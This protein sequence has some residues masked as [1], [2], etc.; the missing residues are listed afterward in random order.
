MSGIHQINYRLA[1]VLIVTLALIPMM[2]SADVYIHPPAVITTPGTYVLQS[3]LTNYAG[4]G[5]AVLILSNDVVLDGNGQILDGINAPSSQGIVVGFG[6]QRVHVKD[7]TVTDFSQGILYFIVSDGL[8]EHCT[9]T[10]NGIGIA[11]F[12]SNNIDVV[13]NTANANTNAGIAS[14]YGTDNVIENNGASGNPVGIY[15]F[16]SV[17][18][19]IIDNQATGNTLYGIWYVGNDGKLDQNDASTNRHIGIVAINSDDALIA[20][21]TVESNVYAIPFTLD[22]GIFVW[23]SPP[24]PHFI[25]STGLNIDNNSV[26]SNQNGIRLYF[27]SHD[28]NV[29]NNSVVLNNNNGIELRHFLTRYNRVDNNSVDDNYGYGIVLYGAPLNII[30]NNT[31]DNNVEGIVL[32][33][34]AGVNS[35]NNLVLNNTVI[36]S[37]L[38]GPPGSGMKGIRLEGISAASRITGNTI[39]SN[40]VKNYIEGIYLRFAGA[41]TILN[42]TIIGNTID[43]MWLSSSLLNT[44]YNNCFNNSVNV[45]FDPLTILPNNWNTL[46]APGPN[47]VG[48]KYFGGNYWA[49]PDGTGHSQ[50]T[51]PNADEFSNAALSIAAGNTDNFPLWNPL[52]ASFTVSD[53]SGNVPLTV[54]FT[55]TSLGNPTCWYWDLN[56][57]GIIDSRDQNPSYTYTEVGTYIITLTVS[58]CQAEGCAASSTY[59][60][61]IV[62]GPHADFSAQPTAGPAPLLVT[63]TDLSTPNNTTSWTWEYRLNGS[64]SW[65]Q[66]ST[67]KDPMYQFETPGIYDINLTVTGIVGPDNSTEK[68]SYIDVRTPFVPVADFTAAPLSGVKPLR[69]QFTDLSTN[70]P[71]SWDWD[72]G[73]TSLHSS[74]QNPFHDYQNPGTY[75]VTLIAS[76]T[77]GASAPVTKTDYITVEGP[78]ADFIASPRTGIK[79]L[80][81]YFTDLSTNGPS[82]WKWEYR[83]GANPYT[84]FATTQ[85]SSFTFPD[86]GM[87]D[88]RLTVDEAQPWANTVEKTGYITVSQI[89]APEA[90]FT[91][92]PRSG[93]RPLDV[94]FTD[95]SSGNP[96]SLA[97]DFDGDGTIDVMSAENPTWTYT[98]AGTY[99]VKLIATND[100]G[101]NTNTKNAYIV[102]DEI[103]V[104]DVDFTASPRTGSK[105]LTVFFT[106]LSTGNPY[107]WDWDFNNDGVIDSHDPQPS[108]IY[109]APG[110]YTV[111][112]TAYNAGGSSTFIKPGYITVSE[113]PAPVSNFTASP[114]IGTRPL[115]VYFTD[116]TSGNPTTWAWDFN[117]DGIVDSNERNPSYTYTSPGTYTVKLNVS[118]AGG[119]NINTIPAYIQVNDVPFPAA[120]FVATPLS[121]ITPVTVAFTDTS[122]GNPTSWEWNFGDGN[123]SYLQSPTHTYTTPRKYTVTLTVSNVRGSNSI[124]KPDYIY[125]KNIPP[126]ADFTGIPTS[127]DEPLTVHFTDLSTGLGINSWQWTFG[128]SGVSTFQ[129][130]AYIYN[131]NGTY[132]V[133]LTVSNDGGS[134]TKTRTAYITVNPAP[135]ANIIQLY[136]GWNFVSVPKMLASGHDTAI[137]VFGGVDLGGHAVLIWDASTGMWKQVTAGTVLKPLDGIW[138]FSVNRMD[139]NLTF[140]PYHVPSPTSKQLYSGWNAIGY[141]GTTSM[142]AHNFLTIGGGLNDNW[143]ILLGYHNGILPDT[144]IIRNSN[145]GLPMYPTKGYWIAMS[146]DDTLTV[147]V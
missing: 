3:G 117:N 145:D 91:A 75:T 83:T 44:I 5:P 55:D 17:R 16:S 39:D 28:N 38:P 134:N 97:W 42:N 57:D 141:A 114:R 70:N 9:A 21:N 105:P 98:A 122:G 125:V 142:S 4:P 89:P 121:G 138:I 146:T 123:T 92:T 84:V 40:L 68:Y 106:D 107:N 100:G 90:D 108:Y 96:T 113:I 74:N 99:T 53:T 115:T 64:L 13:E 54:Y 71:T 63:F 11:L 43:G 88:I 137:D 67:I 103:P 85:D 60:D 95:L 8:V 128:D 80:T 104:P 32:F 82:S 65:T 25:D 51:P 12:A 135:P 73:D 79:P 76:N 116:L 120:N 118:N 6:R 101:S 41:N 59:V 78:Q 1:F 23:N 20:N 143:D 24:L 10:S 129:N 140:D 112:L 37:L 36:H 72:F 49:K 147:V 93:I 35:N 52:S 139:V 66:F 86:P 62:V 30:S 130:P 45:A 110:T 131:T 94:A 18:E 136:P 48:G 7:V 29:T 87:Y 127:G 2:A 26:R 126:V 47:I 31:I 56:G 111:R 77:G 132:T 61:P 19:S 124:T 133:T 144:P 102:V 119:Y 33:P 46:I 58:R 27:R 69:V 14:L 15:V 109:T 50:V 34:D 81:V 22:S